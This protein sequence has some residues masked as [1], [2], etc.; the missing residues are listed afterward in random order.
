[1]K[2]ITLLLICLSAAMICHADPN[3]DEQKFLTIEGASPKFYPNKAEMFLKAD[4]PK[5][6]VSILA[7]HDWGRDDGKLPESFIGYSMDLNGDGKKEYFIESI[8]GGSGGP[9]FFVLTQIQDTWKIILDFQGGFGVIPVEGGWPKIV[10]TGRGGG[11]NWSKT[12]YVF[13]RG[14]YH[15]TLHEG[16]ARG[17]ITKKPIALPTSDKESKKP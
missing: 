11:G 7:G 16:Y 14:S 15:P 2:S 3:E 9:A 5:G 6:L 1:M 13:H 4:L 17:T 10:C 12:H 8:Y